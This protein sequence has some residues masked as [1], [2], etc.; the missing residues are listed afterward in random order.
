V[1]PAKQGFDPDDPATDEIDLRLVMKRELV[2]AQ[3]AANLRFEL[4]AA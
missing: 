2:V 3:G 1:R 4:D